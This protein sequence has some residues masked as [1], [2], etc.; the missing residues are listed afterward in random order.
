MRLRPSQRGVATLSGVL[1]ALVW[2]VCANPSKAE[3]GC[4]HYAVAGKNLNLLSV[5]LDILDRHPAVATESV[6]VETPARPKRCSG[7]LCSGKPAVPLPVPVA[8][9]ATRVEQWGNIELPPP[10][11]PADG[12]VAAHTEHF[13]HAILD[14]PSIDRPPRPSYLPVS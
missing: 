9:S 10:L 3:A 8:P 1:I 11:E 13:V 6:P 14:G 5:R 7:A 2:V 4:S 12:R